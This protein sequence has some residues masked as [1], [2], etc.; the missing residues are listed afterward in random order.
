MDFQPVWELM[1]KNTLKM[2]FSLGV[3]VTLRLGS[4]KY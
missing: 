4:E 1:G 3:E 2:L